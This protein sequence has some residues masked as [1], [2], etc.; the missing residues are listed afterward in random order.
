MLQCSIQSHNNFG[1]EHLQAGTLVFR[2][3]EKLLLQKSYIVLESR[4]MSNASTQLQKVTRNW[5]RMLQS[6]HASIQSHTECLML[7]FRVT[8]VGVECSL[9]GHACIQSHQWNASR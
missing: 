5:I 1:I 9:D 2:V 8:K 6:G 3:T 4:R 7:V